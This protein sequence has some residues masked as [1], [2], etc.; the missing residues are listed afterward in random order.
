[1]NG[2]SHRLNQSQVFEDQLFLL[3]R[4]SRD[5]MAVARNGTEH[6]H[7]DFTAMLRLNDS[8]AARFVRFAPDGVMLSRG[9]NVVH[10]DAKVGKSI[11]RGAYE[12]YVNY[13]NAGCRVILFV[14]YEKTIYWQHIEKLRLIPGEDTVSEFPPE[15]RFPII[16]GWISPRKASHY[17]NGQRRMSGTDYREIDFSSM[18]VLCGIEKLRAPQPNTEPCPATKN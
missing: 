11:E 1:M 17:R 6:T 5:I 2:F 9:K 16:N 8:A 4:Q 18:N 15:R 12:A 10:Y 3:L 14:R 13:R 7:P